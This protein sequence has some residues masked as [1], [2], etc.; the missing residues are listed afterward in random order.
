MRSLKVDTLLLN[1]SQH[2][3]VLKYMA[4]IHIHGHLKF[5]PSSETA[6]IQLRVTNLN[7]TYDWIKSKYYNYNNFNLTLI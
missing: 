2:N 7:E 4:F 5:R 1:I 6:A 3:T